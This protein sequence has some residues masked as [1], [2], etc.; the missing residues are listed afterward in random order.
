VPTVAA[1]LPH[2]AGSFQSGLLVMAGILLAIIA[3][4]LSLKL[5]IKVE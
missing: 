1:K 2:A 4:A 3:L 5:V